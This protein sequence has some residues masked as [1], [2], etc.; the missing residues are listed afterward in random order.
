VTARGF[1]GFF[2]SQ[3][4]IRVVPAGNLAARFD[5]DRPTPRESQTVFFFDQ[6]TG[7][8]SSWA[9]DFGDRASGGSN[10]SSLP[11][12]THVYGSPGSYTVRLTVGKGSQQ[13]SSSK[14]I[15]VLCRRC[16]IVVPARPVK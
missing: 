9:W 12:A 8:P 11:D 7:C 13:V 6:S 14:K 5:V 15:T 4:T 2:T 3:Q 16:P 1:G 10:T